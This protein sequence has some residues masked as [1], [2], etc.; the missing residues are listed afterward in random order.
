MADPSPEALAHLLGVID[1]PAI[2]RCVIGR[3]RPVVTGRPHPQRRLPVAP[4]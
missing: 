2:A 1:D 4:L 3:L